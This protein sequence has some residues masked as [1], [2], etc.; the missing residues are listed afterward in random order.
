MR[1]SWRAGE[2]PANIS[3][4]PAYPAPLDWASWIAAAVGTPLAGPPR[5]LFT[6]GGWSVTLVLADR[7]ADT[8][9]LHAFYA[10]FDEVIHAWADFP[11]AAE[12]SLA[13]VAERFL[14]A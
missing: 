10:P 13:A 7:D 12:A 2:H 5:E 8:R 1:L 11:A 14:D 6:R 4:R 9:R 3:V